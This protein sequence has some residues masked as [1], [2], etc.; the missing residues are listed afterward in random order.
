MPLY[1]IISCVLLI[2]LFSCTA[3]CQ[4]VAEVLL[5]SVAPLGTVSRRFNFFNTRKNLVKKLPYNL[6]LTQGFL[7]QIANRKMYIFTYGIMYYYNHILTAMAEACAYAVI[8]F[9]DLNEPDATL[10]AATPVM[11]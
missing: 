11:T 1:N 6:T 4:S 5:T 9:P 10:R 8:S 7:Y 2:T 3:I